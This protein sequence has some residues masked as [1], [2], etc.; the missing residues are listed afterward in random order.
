LRAGI[1]ASQVEDAQAGTVGVLRVLA[2]LEHSG[3]VSARVWADIFRFP[4][5]PV[6]DPKNWTPPKGVE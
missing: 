6:M 4:Q 3:E 2:G 5:E 1:A